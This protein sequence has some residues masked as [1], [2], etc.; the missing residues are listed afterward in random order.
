M[1]SDKPR[2]RNVKKLQPNDFYSNISDLYSSGSRMADIKRK[3]ALKYGKF[4][5]QEGIE[6]LVSGCLGSQDP[7]VRI[8]ARTHLISCGSMVIGRL[9]LELENWKIA[10]EVYRIL[11]E[12]NDDSVKPHLMEQ[13]R[14]QNEFSHEAAYVLYNWD[15]T[16]PENQFEFISEG[17]KSGDYKIRCHA[18]RA[19]GHFEEMDVTPMLLEMLDD[20]HVK[21][22]S[23]AMYTLACID[24]RL[25]NTHILP[26]INSNIDVDYGYLVYRTIT[27]V[28]EGLGDNQAVGHLIK[29][30]EVKSDYARARCQSIIMKLNYDSAGDLLIANFNEKPE[31]TKLA[32]VRITGHW[33][34]EQSIQFL[35]R[36]FYDSSESVASLAADK[37]KNLGIDVN[38]F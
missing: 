34:C 11:L 6:A 24:D 5:N 16:W 10:E 38:P 29:F 1:T 4:C 26:I 8:L 32:I 23:E 22:K 7:D 25:V 17:L 33:G 2:K 30:F 36:A 15:R 28:L 14:K 21:V 13:Y 3:N 20:T 18:I 27:N 37:L 31:Q 9:I 12:I 35:Q 19:I